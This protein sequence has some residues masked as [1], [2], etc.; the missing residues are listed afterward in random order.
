MLFVTLE[1]ENMPI[2]S[3]AMTTAAARK[4][5]EEA[6]RKLDTVYMQF[7]SKRG[8]AFDGQL[9]KLASQIRKHAEKL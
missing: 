5:L 3:R 2:K 7:R 6:A 8:G 1:G 9:I 4:R